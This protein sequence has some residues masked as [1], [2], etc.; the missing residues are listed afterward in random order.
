VIPVCVR[1]GVPLAALM[2][3]SL[4][5]TIAA[6]DEIVLRGG[7]VERGEVVRIDDDGV[8]I[9][10][11]MHHQPGTWERIIGWDRVRS[12]HGALE[13]EA[14][15]YAAIADMVWRA[16][17]R[18]ERGDFV[19]AAASFESLYERYRGQ[20][21]PTALVVTEGVLRCR[22]HQGQAAHRVVGPYLETLRLVRLGVERTAFRD[23]R[24]VIDPET[25]LCPEL[26]PV[27]SSVDDE[28]RPDLSSL[29]TD[30]DA[31]VASLAQQYDQLFRPA[32]EALSPVVT[33]PTTPESG[34]NLVHAMV[35]AV[36]SSEAGRQAGRERLREL[37]ANHRGDWQEAWCRLG[38]GESLLL[39]EGRE[40]RLGG[41]LEL[42]HV[43][44]RMGAEFPEF[45]A[46]AV[47]LAAAELEAQ[48]MADD[49][50]QIKRDYGD[51]SRASRR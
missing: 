27:R 51:E 47:E 33:A 21:S 30:P 12:V 11:Q 48:G 42:L 23:L 1:A 18:L 29:T 34:P 10:L 16:R 31:V 15:D 26:L 36:G 40:V 28:Q 39:D 14:H 4:V 8:T 43:P 46:R 5:L 9:L 24:P 22:L 41:V 37:T 25:L 3:V 13:A 17:Y 7:T 6:G 38:T 32:V 19:L 45:A 50:A 20:T 2:W 44:I 49:A 35:V